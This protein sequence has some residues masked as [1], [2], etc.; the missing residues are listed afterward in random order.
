MDVGRLRFAARR[1]DGLDESDISLPFVP[2]WAVGQPGGRCRPTAFGHRSA[3]GADP[4]ARA[5]G[6]ICPCSRPRPVLDVTLKL[7]PRDRSS[8]VG[9]VGVDE[10]DCSRPDEVVTARRSG[11]PSRPSSL[12]ARASRRPTAPC[13]RGL[14]RLETSFGRPD[15]KE[16]GR[17]V[18]AA[19]VACVEPSTHLLIVVGSHVTSAPS[20][21]A[22]MA[23]R[24][25]AAVR[26]STVT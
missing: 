12:S 25:P 14:Q 13:R 6:A 11:A 15:R 5:A 23:T 10:A 22:M 17:R 26:F 24:L 7:G 16:C 9:G 21:A 19:R 18:D 4:A 3:S 2:R 20:L 1:S 8:A